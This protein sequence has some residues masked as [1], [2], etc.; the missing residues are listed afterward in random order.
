MRLL[1]ALVIAFSPAVAH[2]EEAWS[3]GFHFAHRAELEGFGWYLPNGF[4]TRVPVHARVRLEVTTAG[5]KTTEATVADVT[6]ARGHRRLQPLGL[7]AVVQVAGPLYAVAGGGIAY[8][9]LGLRYPLVEDT[10]WMDAGSSWRPHAYAGAGAAWRVATLPNGAVT[11][12]IDVRGCALGGSAAGDEQY[13]V[14]EIPRLSV[15]GAFV[16]GLLF[17]RQH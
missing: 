12:G 16:V 6:E 3:L 5:F 9:Q 15:E 14:P 11:L 1:L 10:G 7:G 4:D 2:A 17:D 8:E 13:R